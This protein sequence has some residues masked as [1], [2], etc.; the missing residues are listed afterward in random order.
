MKTNYISMKKFKD[1]KGSVRYKADPAVT[2]PTI[3]DVYITNIFKKIRK[4]K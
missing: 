2:S 4:D 1:C 3:T